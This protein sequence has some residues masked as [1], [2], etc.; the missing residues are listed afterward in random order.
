MAL[1]LHALVADDRSG[2]ARDLAG[3]VAAVIVVDVDARV[4]KRG[5]EGGDGLG[6]RRLLIVAGQ[7]DRDAKLRLIHSYPLAA[8]AFP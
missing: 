3:A 5:A 8:L 4:R 6:D 2:R 1:A 7:Q